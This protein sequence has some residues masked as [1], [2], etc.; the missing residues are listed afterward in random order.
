M[1]AQKNLPVKVSKEKS[2][3]NPREEGQDQ[4]HEMKEGEEDTEA[5]TTGTEG[6]VNTFKVFVRQIIVI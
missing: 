4:G 6:M 1:R 2:Q 5:G 3:R